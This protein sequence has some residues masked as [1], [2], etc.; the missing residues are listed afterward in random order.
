[1]TPHKTP[2]KM[3]EYFK[4]TQ[5]ELFV[6]GF[7]TILGFINNWVLGIFTILMGL[8]VHTGTYLIIK[9]QEKRGTKR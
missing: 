8:F 2:T 6:F 5:I 3:K 1:M 9:F 4:F 7:M